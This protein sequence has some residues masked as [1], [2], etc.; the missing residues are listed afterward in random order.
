VLVRDPH[1]QFTPQAFLSTQLATQPVQILE[2]FVMRWHTE[3]TFREARAHLGVETQRQWADKA[4]VR[5]TP[6]LFGLF[7]IITLLAHV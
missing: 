6:A 4:I 1:R 7:S 2:W 5:T 3:V